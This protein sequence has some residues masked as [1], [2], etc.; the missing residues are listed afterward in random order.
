MRFIDCARKAGVTPDTLRH[1][2]R[3]GL[4]APAG[5]A[6]N[7]YRIF[8]KS[9]LA[10]L[11]FIRAALNLGFTLKD[12]QAL[13]AVVERGES[14][15]EL[16]RSLLVMRARQQHERLLAAEQQLARMCAA[17]EQWQAAEDKPLGL[18]AVCGLINSATAGDKSLTACVD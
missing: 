3:I 11:A 1:Y 4:V 9:A 8:G 12:V 17:L 5:R 18:D 14:P 7:G 16:A 13:I 2:V 15:C 10:R 6:G